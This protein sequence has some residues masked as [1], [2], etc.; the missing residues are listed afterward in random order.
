MKKR[1]SIIAVLVMSV[2]VTAYSVSG[3]Y[4]KYTSTA[5]VSDNARVAQFYVNNGIE[6]TGIFKN[7]Y[8][9]GK[10]NVI[11][12]G[13]DNAKVIAPGTG[14]EIE[15]QIAGN[16]ET[17]YTLD[18]TVKLTPND[19]FTVKNGSKYFPIVFSLYIEDNEEE[20][21]Y[22]LLTSTKNITV[23]EAALKNSLNNSSDTPVIYEPGEISLSKYKIAWSWPFE[24]DDEQE[25]GKKNITDEDDTYLGNKEELE[26]LDKIELSI[27]FNATQSTK[28][29]T[30][31]NK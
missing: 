12:K 13:K 15:F 1:L 11:V 21:G 29:V 27:G 30:K 2:I 14:N 19:G 4:A 3:T 10:D 9:L 23:L 22:S 31:L 26:N 18:A 8:E 24:V 5:G 17:N 20:S 16:V 25:E 28:E 6:D 7:A